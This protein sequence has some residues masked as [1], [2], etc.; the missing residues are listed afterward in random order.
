M[1]TKEMKSK[2]EKSSIAIAA[3]STPSARAAQ[4]RTHAESMNVAEKKAIRSTRTTS[5]T[6]VRL[7]H[8]S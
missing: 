4:S 2:R 7:M 8:R 6:R 3:Y 1:M 5:A